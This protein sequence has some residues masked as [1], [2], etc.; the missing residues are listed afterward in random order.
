[1]KKG[2][3]IIIIATTELF[4]C[5]QGS[6]STPETV[7]IETINSVSKYE[8]ADSTGKRLIIHNSFP[9]G[10]GYIDP[11]GKRHPYAVFYSQII[12]ETIN[13]LKL[14]LDFPLDS[15]EFRFHREIA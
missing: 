13:P 5:K 1:M 15:F 11:K 9:R 7:D 12:N 10:G 4:S 3:I 6:K 8:Y 2:I 14:R